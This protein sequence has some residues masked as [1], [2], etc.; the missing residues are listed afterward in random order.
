MC[1]FGETVQTNVR[2]V[3]Q[4]KNEFAAEPSETEDEAIT[5]LQKAEYDSY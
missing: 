5:C 2:I 1:G 3:K 4:R